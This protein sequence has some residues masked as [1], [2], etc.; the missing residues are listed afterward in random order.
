MCV[1]EKK[2]SSQ[3]SLRNDS[4]GTARHSVPS[5]VSAT[6]VEGLRAFVEENDVPSVV[7]AT[8][9]EGLRAFVKDMLI[10][11]Q[12]IAFVKEIDVPSVDPVTTVKGL[13]AFVKENLIQNH[14]SFY[15][16]LIHFRHIYQAPK[17]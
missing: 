4:E 14:C 9:V 5:V 17:K 7:S 13:R 11:N 6:T 8:T 1:I 15:D 2:L 3:R 12:S 10:P 16:S